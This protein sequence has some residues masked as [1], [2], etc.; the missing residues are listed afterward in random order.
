MRSRVGHTQCLTPQA[1]PV[2]SVHPA[3]PA[4]HVRAHWG[5]LR[6]PAGL[7]LGGSSSRSG[8]V[9]LKWSL[10]GLLSENLHS[11]ALGVG[12]GV[13]WHTCTGSWSR[14]SGVTLKSPRS[15]RWDK[16]PC[17]LLPPSSPLCAPPFTPP[18]NLLRSELEP[19]GPSAQPLPGAQ[20][21]RVP[22]T[23]ISTQKIQEEKKTSPPAGK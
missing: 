3:G 22:Q 16:A 23:E 20:V 5:H 9:N 2:T 7:C 8:S 6:A 11:W 21:T 13:S 14:P 17:G 19:R 4:C 18:H 1:L 12:V 10:M 15:C